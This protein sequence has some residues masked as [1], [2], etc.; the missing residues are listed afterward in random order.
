MHHGKSWSPSHTPDSDQKDSPCPKSLLCGALMGMVPGQG[1]PS[2]CG[3]VDARIP[4]LVILAV[5]LHSSAPFSFGA[6]CWGL[7]QR[8]PHA[9]AKSCQPS[10]L[11]PPGAPPPPSIQ[12]FP[13][14]SLPSFSISGP[15][16]NSPFC[17]CQW[18]HSLPSPMPGLHAIA[19]PH[20]P[21]AECTSIFLSLLSHFCLPVIRGIKCSRRL[22]GW[23][24]PSKGYREAAKCYSHQQPTL[25]PGDYCRGVRFVALPDRWLRVI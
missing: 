10:L 12:G 2:G 11:S 3:K 24:E 14:T 19:K 20:R 13:C 16:C 8:L 15:P 6:V 23:P 5:L 21:G 1:S 4:R 25:S 7:G 22:G 9:R 17:P 18:L